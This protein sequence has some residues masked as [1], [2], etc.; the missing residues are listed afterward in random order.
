[1][2]CHVSLSAPEVL[3]PWCLLG[4]TCAGLGL[5]PA[6]PPQGLGVPGDLCWQDPSH[7]R[8]AH[9]TSASANPKP[10]SS[11]PP[12]CGASAAPLPSSCRATGL[13]RLCLSLVCSFCPECLYVGVRAHSAGCPAW[14][15]CPGSCRSPL[16]RLL[17]RPRPGSGCTAACCPPPARDPAPA[18]A[19]QPLLACLGAGSMSTAQ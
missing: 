2:L 10:E 3:V 1:M 9:R 6:G 14:P 12:S 18:L 7:P 11:M 5:P 15:C 19:T 4:G 17:C 8:A 13:S 16:T